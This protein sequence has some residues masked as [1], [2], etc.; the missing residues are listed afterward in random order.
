MKKEYISHVEKNLYVIT[1]I[2][3]AEMNIILVIFIKRH[4]QQENIETAI[5]CALVNN[6]MIVIFVKRY[7]LQDIILIYIKDFIYVRNLWH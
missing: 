6:T 7:L 3:T 5:K 4:S 2:F 1:Q